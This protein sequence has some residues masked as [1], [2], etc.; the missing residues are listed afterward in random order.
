MSKLNE[1]IFLTV[2]LGKLLLKSI[3][4]WSAS[5]ELTVICAGDLQTTF[6]PLRSNPSLNMLFK[7]VSI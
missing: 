7:M 6:V 4:M 2:A 1:I 5:T 3:V